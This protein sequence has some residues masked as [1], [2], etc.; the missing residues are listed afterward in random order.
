M[1]VFKLCLVG[2]F[3]ASVCGA[4]SINISG[5]VTDTDG[6][7]YQTVRIGSQ[8][9]MAENLKTTKYNDGNAIPFV[10][11]NTAWSNLITPGY[12]WYN[13]DSVTNRNTYGA[14]YNWYTVNTGKLAP[15]GWHVPTDSE[16]T[17]LTTYLGGE[18]LAGGKLKEAGTA[19][20]A[21]PNTHATNETGF[22]ELPGGCRGNDSPFQGIGGYST[23]WSCTA[24][25]PTY[26]WYR[27]FYFNSPFAERITVVNDAWGFSVR[28]IK[29]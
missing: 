19:H 17:V 16:W 13:N 15:S 9:W 2:I 5:K 11:D 20:W 29:N 10:M 1:I 12:C 22:S 7:V 28:C 24:A 8:I 23:L 4:Q 14:L 6:N 26:S 25:G 18:S 3:A 27:N 21:S